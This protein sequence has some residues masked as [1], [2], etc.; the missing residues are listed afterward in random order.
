MPR[1]RECVWGD[2]RGWRFGLARVLSVTML[3]AALL[4][5]L[6][7]G[8]G[9]FIVGEEDAD[10]DRAGVPPPQRIAMAECLVLPRAGVAQRSPAR[11][12]PV[13]AALIRGEFAAP[14]DGDAFVAHDGRELR[15]VTVA[16]GDDGWVKGAFPGGYAFWSV[17]SEFERVMLLEARGH[18][19]VYVNGE[20]RAG[21]PYLTG[22]VRLP[23]HLKAGRNEFLFA[24]AR[25]TLKA[26][27]M[28][29]PA[30]VF[31][32]AEDM[33]WPDIVAA[34]HPSWYHGAVTIVNATREA[35]EVSVLV[36]SQDGI[37]GNGGGWIMPLT[38]LKVPVFFRVGAPTGGGGTMHYSLRLR[39]RDASGEDVP[40]RTLHT[41]EVEI[42]VVGP[43]EPRRVTFVSAID[44]SVQYYGLLPARPL[45][46]QQEP[47]GILLSLHG[48]SVEAINQARAYSPKSWCH[49]VCPT[50][51]R[52]FGFDWEDWGRKDALEVLAHA[53]ETLAHDARRIWLTG[54]SMGGHGAWQLGAH[55]PCHWAAI[56][57]SAGWES[58]WSYS[59]SGATFDESDPVGALLARAANPSRTLLLKRNYAQHG[60]YILHGDADDNVPVSEARRMRDALAEFHRDLAWHEEPGAGHWWDRGHDDG[61]DCVDWQP[62]MDF[63]ARRRVPAAH[64]VSLVDFT[65]VDP[66]ISARCHWLEIH[67]Q[68]RQLAPSRARVR[69]D[70]NRGHFEGETENITLLRLDVAAV[71]QPRNELIVRL[72][73]IE[74]EEPWPRGGVLW[75]LRTED[76]WR[77][78]VPP[79][80]PHKGSERYGGFKS[81]FDNGFVLVVGGAGSDEETWRNYVKARYDAE[82]WW[83]RANGRAEI[84]LDDH[85]AAADWQGRNVVIYGNADTH[86]LWDYLMGAADLRV[87]RDTLRVGEHE[88]N[89]PGMAALF[90]RPRSGSARA[91]VGVVAGTGE[92]I[93][94]TERVA[95]ATSGAGFPDLIVYG[96]DAP[97]LGAAGVRAAGWFGP[98]WG[99]AGGEIAMAGE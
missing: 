72:D 21:D 93:R 10:D 52:P 75:L 76:G 5:A 46:D 41:R 63:F 79:P 14:R 88:W 9:R 77:A 70:V 12:D 16:A 86:A 20:P 24:C 90:V 36:E 32:Q 69:A 73:G 82:Q 87:T 6:S 56:G 49:I 89:E 27:L 13:E 18:A 31:I 68:A 8:P 17:Q 48:A 40:W 39:V 80:V 55:Y 71:M 23:V 59:G 43:I 4:L 19:M 97:L 25:A 67:M 1:G 96:P 47:P 85:F 60:V 28:K 94:L 62:M 98:G 2:C 33:T 61:A 83:L 74:L 95:W 92:G 26:E 78:T 35:V 7:G 53:R 58:F 51:R 50:N 38:V 84:L 54:H 44:R 15:W 11:V 30:P 3:L 64:E 81:A 34:Q 37:V 45:P 99:L 42:P 57:P 65:T 66:G 29:P 22:H 91:L